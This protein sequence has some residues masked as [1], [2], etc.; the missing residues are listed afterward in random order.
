MLHRIALLFHLLGLV[1]FIGGAVA[2]TQLIKASAAKELNDAVRDKYEELAAF[3][4]KKLELPGL[5]LQIASG[6]LFIYLF[7]GY[8]KAPWLHIKL[9]FVAALLVLCHMEM[10][11]ASRIVKARKAGN[12]SEIDAR[13]KKHSVMGAIGT[14]CVVAI[15]GVVIF[16]R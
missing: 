5:F 3:C 16:G 12:L 8:L 15:V 11:N 14:V 2:Q 7:P 6:A 9:T 10:I 4:S 1:L 13:K